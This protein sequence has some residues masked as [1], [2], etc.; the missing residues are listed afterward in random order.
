MNLADQLSG[1]FTRH[2]RT[3]PPMRR[4]V[5]MLRGCVNS[6]SSDGGLPTAADPRMILGLARRRR[7]RLGDRSCARMRMQVPWAGCA[8]QSC[9][10]APRD[11]LGTGFNPR[12]RAQRRDK[13]VLLETRPPVRS[14]SAPPLRF[15][16]RAE[17]RCHSARHQRPSRREGPE[18][19]QRDQPRSHRAAGTV[20]ATVGT[21]RRSGPASVVGASS[22]GSAPGR[23]RA[24]GR[25]SLA[26]VIETG[27]DAVCRFR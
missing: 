21:G 25:R 16:T 27:A 6:A 4:N 9:E 17:R 23:R 7:G 20:S 10:T 3:E 14:R 22:C 24:P 15:A 2:K 26:F 13:S 8:R 18:R 5:S 1:A 19:D 11:R 12:P